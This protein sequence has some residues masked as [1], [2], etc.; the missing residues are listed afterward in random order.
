MITSL[1]MMLDHPEF[2]KLIRSLISH[3][4]ILFKID[5]T[6]NKGRWDDCSSLR[7]NALNYV[8]QIKDIPNIEHK[9]KKEQRGFHH[10]VTMRLLCPQQ[11]RENFDANMEGF[12]CNV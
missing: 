9:V 7:N 4:S 10:F 11:L 1:E 8:P 5:A 2:A 12:C 6:S 3:S